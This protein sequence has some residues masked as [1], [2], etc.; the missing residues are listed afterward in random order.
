[1]NKNPFELRADVL[2]MA[3]DY[4]DKQNELNTQVA[5]KLYEIG[6]Q[7][8]EDFQ[9]AMKGYDIQTLTETAKDMYSFVSKKD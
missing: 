7:N 8:Q 3:K 5:T 9:A 1:M 4:L 2:A 6:Q